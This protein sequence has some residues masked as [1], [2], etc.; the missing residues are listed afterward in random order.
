MP[1]G[2]GVVIYSADQGIYQ[3]KK[4]CAEATGVACLLDK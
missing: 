3:T 1:D 4:E 2:D